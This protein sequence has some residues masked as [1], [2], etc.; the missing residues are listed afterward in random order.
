MYFF[1]LFI[2]Y[3]LFFCKFCAIISINETRI[4]EREEKMFYQS[5]LEFL[6]EI[7]RKKH[8][9]T[10]LLSV[11]DLHKNA[12]PHGENIFQNQA[13]LAKLLPTVRP[14]QLYKFADAYSRCYY[15]LQL[16]DAKSA[17]ILC[18]GPFLENSLSPQYLLELAEENGILPQKSAYVLE[19]YRSLTIITESSTLRIMLTAFCERIWG[20]PSFPIVNL[21]ENGLTSDAPFSTSMGNLEPNDTLINKKAIEVRYA[22]ENELIRAVTLGQSHFEAQFKSAFSQELFE[23]RAKNPLQNAKNYSIIMNTLLRKAA[24][25]GGVHPIYLNQVSTEFALKIEALAAPSG[26][27]ELMSEM[28][29]SYCRLVR[30]HAIQK[31]P[32]VVQKTI[33]I[34]D[35][36]LSADLSPK[37]LAKSQGVT[38]GYLSA[39]FRKETG[40]TI[41]QYIC[42]RRMEYAEYL[43][44]ST[45]LQIQTISLH[46]GIMDAQYFS[47]LFKKYKGKTPMQYRRSP[48]EA[49]T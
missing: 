19:Y 41:S 8:V 10:L 34:I 2:F 47:K 24:E 32:L 23:K 17:T 11:A 1:N 7:F 28:F 44:T 18:V 29:R 13:F 6:Q 48:R 12:Q 31:F 22:F 3:L 26:A 36:D 33:L 20:T 21:S 43:L 16:P 30:K 4:Y 45:N 9:N 46:C 35:A 40:K 38:L 27:S 14:R 42:T 5:E 37:L 49:R 15:F 25:Q 39:V